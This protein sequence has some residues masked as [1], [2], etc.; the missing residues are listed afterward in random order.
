M[1]NKFSKGFTLIELMIVVSIIA[2]LMAIVIPNYKDYLIRSRITQATSTL[3]DKRIQIEQYF[4]DNKTYIGAPA[5]V[6]DTAA[7]SYFDF[8]CTVELIGNYT[9]QAVGKGSM[10]G[11]TFTVDQDNLRATPSAA[12]GWPTSA[13]CWVSSKGGAC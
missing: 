1:T 7:S 8:S 2:I 10:T 13:N 5:C 4:Q 9:I 3:A 12:S 6:A 11:F